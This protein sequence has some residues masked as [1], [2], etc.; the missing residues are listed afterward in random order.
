VVEN[1][2]FAMNGGVINGNNANKGGGVFIQDPASF[3]KTAAADGGVIYGEEAEGV[4]A[5]GYSLKNTA[6]SN[7]RG[8]SVYYDSPGPWTKRNATADAMVS[9]STGSDE[10][11]ESD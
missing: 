4:D 3:T 2:S 6:Y 8:H 7:T 11:W 10:N 5:A 9:L 1:S